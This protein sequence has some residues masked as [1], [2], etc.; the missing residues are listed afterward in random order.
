MTETSKAAQP[1]TIANDTLNQLFRQAR[2]HSAWLPKRV[3]VEVLREVY[4]LARWGPT[5]ANCTP[6][7]FVFLESE[8]AKARLLPALAPGNIEKTKAAPVT[9]IVAWDT[10]FYE[11]LPQLF[12]QADMRS[13]FVGKQ[14]LIDETALRNGSL[15]GGYFILAARALGLDCGP[16][17]GFDAAKV[18]AEFFPDGKWKA[19]FL[20]NLGYGDRSKLFLRNPRLEFDEACRVL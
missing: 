17:S 11:R 20:C 2:T 4:E 7:R 9:V 18:N 12:P 8:A 3:P 15:Q 16:M 6:A 10:E 14:P 13:Y 1:A 19:N 5:S